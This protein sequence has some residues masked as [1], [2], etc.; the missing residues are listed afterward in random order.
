MS[1]A[2]N[3][4]FSILRGGGS[5]ADKQALQGTAGTSM[6][7]RN[8]RLWTPKKEGS[9]FPFGRGG[10][11]TFDNTAQK[12]FQ[13]TA[14]IACPPEEILAVRLHAAQYSPATSG[15]G[16]TGGC[17]K[18]IAD[19]S[20]INGVG[21]DDWTPI[22]FGSGGASLVMSFPS[23]GTNTQ[24]R[25]LGQTDYMELPGK[26]RTDG[27]SMFAFVARLYVAS[28]STALRFV[29][30]G[31][32]DLTG[33]ANR[34]DRKWIMRHNDG[35]CTTN[36]NPDN[37]TS[38]VNRSQSPIAGISFITKTRG[39]ITLMTNDDSI[40]EGQTVA[41][42]QAIACD[43]W[44]V[45]AAEQLQAAH[46]YT[47]EVVN[48]SWSSGN[49][50]AFFARLSDMLDGQG[51]T[52]PDVVFSSL[53]TPNDFGSSGISQA[54]F[55]RGRDQVKLFQAKCRAYGAALIARTFLPVDPSLYDWGAAD[56]QRRAWNAEIAA[57]DDLPFADFAPVF[58]GEIV[59][60]GQQ[61]PKPGVA[62]SIGIH[63]NDTVRGPLGRVAAQAVE[64]ALNLP[65][66]VP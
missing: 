44:A 5:A 19:V 47:V 59:P 6:V 48:N 38:T 34:A 8:G 61:I 25:F 33:W 56:V 64:R 27:G 9:R 20:N 54:R 37:F 42:G 21:G 50:A 36:G 52:P 30:N 17:I 46:G 35:D 40:G 62:D 12:T 53:T 39:V 31:T 49:S 24:R 15:Y 26:T 23:V 66:L 7:S 58:S 32:D 11:V 18:S 16:I 60:S 55:S 63:P 51:I 28:S 1:A 29:G 3:K 22:T 4:A 13:L 10:V 14:E 43:G 2:G 45:S 65:A 41:G 57:R